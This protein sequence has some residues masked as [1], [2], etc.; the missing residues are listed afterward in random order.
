VVT[1]A[2]TEAGLVVDTQVAVT[3]VTVPQAAVAGTVAVAV[4][5]PVLTAETVKVDLDTLPVKLQEA[6]V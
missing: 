1:F 6:E 2:V 4:V 5:T 3:D